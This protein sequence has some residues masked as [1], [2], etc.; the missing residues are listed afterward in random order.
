[1]TTPDAPATPDETAVPAPRVV[2]A[3][4]Q[5]LVRTGFRLILTARG[6]DVVGVAADGVEAVAAVR[7]LRPDVVL[8]DI[9]MPNMDGLEAARRILAEAPYCRVIMLTTFDLDQ[10]VYEALAAGASGFLLKDVT[11][12]HLAAA[13]RLVSTGDALLAPSITRRLVERCGPGA[14]AANPAAADT[15]H[16]GLTA[17]TPRE[18][19]VLTLM[20]HGLSNAELARAFTLS[21]ATVKT[22]VARIFAKLSL[23]DRA[24]AVVLAYETGLVTPGSVTAPRPWPP[25]AG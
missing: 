2:I 15:V 18:R 10:Y 22:H 12:A 17:L 4:D 16:Q 23:R 20:G 6:I 14:A 24:Q 1:M 9:R 25:L 19:E 5:D 13:V 21:E 8:L 11:P 3:D 7:R